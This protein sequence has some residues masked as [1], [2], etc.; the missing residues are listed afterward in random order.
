LAEPLEIYTKLNQLSDR[1]HAFAV[2]KTAAFS[3]PLF[4]DI[5]RLR[6]ITCK[7][8]DALNEV[9]RALTTFRDLQLSIST[10]PHLIKN[11]QNIATAIST[12][13]D[14]LTKLVLELDV[15]SSLIM[16]ESMFLVLIRYGPF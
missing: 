12:S 11:V 6:T 7:L 13:R 2:S 5:S 8:V 14:R 1:L 9:V 4:D 15:R 3:I 10:V 16:L